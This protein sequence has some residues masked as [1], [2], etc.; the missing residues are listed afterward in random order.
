MSK[1]LWFVFATGITAISL[2]LAQTNSFDPKKAD[3]ILEITGYTSK[4]ADMAFSPDG[5][6]LA[7]ASA[8]DGSARLWDVEQGRIAT[9]LEG[10]AKFGISGLNYSS[11]G[12]S[13]VTLGNDD[14]LKTWNVT[15]GKETASF[16]LKCNRGGNGDVL[17]LKD[18]RVIV[19]CDGLKMVDLKNGKI[20]GTFKGA[21][22][23][24]KLSLSTDQKTVLG[25]LGDPEFKLWDT[26]SLEAFRTLKGHERQGFA[27]S[28]SANGKFLAT[29]ASDRLV[30]VWNASNGKLLFT[31][32]GHDNSIGDV[33]FSPDS[34]WLATASDDRTVKLWDVATGE[35]I[36]TLE[37]HKQGITQLA[38]SKNGKMLAS[39][40][41]S[42]IIKLWGNP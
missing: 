3:E 4:I 8:E 38:W 29:G 40:D 33:A 12:K 9:Q 6:R 19:A 7:V 42:G 5:K 15:S 10:H 11:D 26:Q 18:N 27:V 22:S 24:Y 37:G 30:K 34:K 20:V 21:S 23:A 14:L 32:K 31:L 39:G 28:Y 1:Q 35:E 17:L 25:S 16:N 2:A 13:L 36:S 41:E